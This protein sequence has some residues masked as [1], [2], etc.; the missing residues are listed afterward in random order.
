MSVVEV[1]KLWV[2]KLSE[3]MSLPVSLPDV[4]GHL[5]GSTEYQ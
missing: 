4:V 3:G 2:Q 1:E 5:V